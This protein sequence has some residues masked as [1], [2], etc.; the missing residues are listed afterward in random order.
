MSAECGNVPVAGVG[1]RLLS[2]GQ[3]RRQSLAA[4]SAQI[5]D[6][7]IGI[8]RPVC[9]DFPQGRHRRFLD[10]LEIVEAASV[11]SVTA[12]RAT[13]SKRAQKSPL[14]AAAQRSVALRE[15]FDR[16]ATGLRAMIEARA[17]QGP[18]GVGFLLRSSYLTIG[19]KISANQR[20]DAQMSGSLTVTLKKS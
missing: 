8:S 5:N 20:R 6:G 9:L 4:T 18:R 1:Q 19:Y 12:S 16:T 15:A 17:W 14:R 7:S 13:R 10:R 3:S 2:V 11:A